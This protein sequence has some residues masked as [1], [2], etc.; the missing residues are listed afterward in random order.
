MK[1]KHA[2]RKLKFV[3][4]LLFTGLS[5]STSAQESDKEEKVLYLGY[6]S[7]MSEEYMKDYAPS[8]EYVMN[9]QLPN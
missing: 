8:L 9:A 7:N 2:F 6:G 3:F 5:L 4:A 1:S